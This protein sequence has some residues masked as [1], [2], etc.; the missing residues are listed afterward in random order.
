VTLRGAVF[1]LDDTLFLE[2]AYVVSGFAAVAND[3]AD[4]YAIE[5]EVI[6]REL[7]VI[8]AG[9]AQ[10]RVF[11]SWLQA[12]DQLPG[13]LTVR[14]L[15]D[16]YR[17]HRPN[18]ALLPGVLDMLE[19]LRNAACRMA[20]VSDGPLQSQ[21]AKV[22]AL[23]LERLVD[24][25]VL[26]DEWGSHF[27]KP[28]RRAFEQLESDWSCSPSEL[29]YV[30][31]NP[32]KDFAGPKSLGW[33]TIRLKLEGQLLHGLEAASVDSS[34]HIEFKSVEELSAFLL[35]H[36]PPMSTLPER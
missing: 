6:V 32:S 2:R 31:D 33:L 18:I 22:E 5:P 8:E 26:T 3:I 17:S 9:G 36:A 10:G 15:V 23:G 20:I 34:A 19:S 30:G 27:W 25:I 21:R 11:N 4:A 13:R 16:I 14:L 28:H 24:R 35:A 12:R 7:L 29:V 1:D